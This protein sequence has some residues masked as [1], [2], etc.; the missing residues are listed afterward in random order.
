MFINF[1][2]N[3]DDIVNY[4][5]PKYQEIQLIILSNID[6]SSNAL[7]QNRNYL[8]LGC[9]TGITV[10]K[11]ILSFPDSCVTGIDSSR[12]MLRKAEV[13]LR[14]FPNK[15]WNLLERDILGRK[16]Y[17]QGFN[18]VI[19][20][21]SFNNINSRF[22]SKIYKNIFYSLA[23]GGKFIYADFI[24]HE[25][26]FINLKLEQLYKKSLYSAIG[27]KSFL[28]NWFEH[29]K[30]GY[31]PVSLTRHFQILE[32]TGFSNIELLWLFGNQAVFSAIKL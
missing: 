26:N 21:M 17:G 9:G 29:S 8:D 18:S 31:Y 23:N 24:K 15:N 28:E 5:I 19:S 22:L 4:V 2:E 12:E 20:V 13:R 25:N 27:D 7:S 10:E 11:I 16:P 6:N 32:K 14:K 3:Y 30:N 1:K